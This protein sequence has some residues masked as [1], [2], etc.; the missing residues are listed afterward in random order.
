MRPAHV[1]RTP[2][3]L[4]GRAVHVQRHNVVLFR[5]LHPW[6]SL[7][8]DLR[9]ICEVQG[10][11]ACDIN[12]LWGAGYWMTTGSCMCQSCSRPSSRIPTSCSL[13]PRT[14]QG[15][16]EAASSCH[17]LS[18]ELPHPPQRTKCYHLAAV[19]SVTQPLQGCI[20]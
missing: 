20:S 11:Q 3:L 14:R 12:R 19:L 8:A 9:S 7:G 18:G 17:V 13:P 16:M 6:N 10:F 1:H 4:P 15:R 5:R 2:A